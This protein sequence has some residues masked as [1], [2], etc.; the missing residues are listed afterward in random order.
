MNDWLKHPVIPSSAVAFTV[1]GRPVPKARARI[2]QRGNYTP[3]ATKQYEAMVSMY[4]QIAMAGRPLL[5][6]PL[7][8]FLLFKMPKPKKLTRKYPS[9]KPDKDNLEKAY[10][11]GMNG[12]VYKDDSQITHGTVWSIYDDEPGVEV[13]VWEIT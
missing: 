5:E 8:M 10:S 4:A 3:A 12:I 6:G 11:D 1:P 7:Y 9:V 13:A 2:T